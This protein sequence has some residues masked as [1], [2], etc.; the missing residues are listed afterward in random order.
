M[1]AAAHGHAKIVKILLGHG[2]SIYHANRYGQTA[3]DVAQ[4]SAGLIVR[5]YQNQYDKECVSIEELQNNI[6]SLKREYSPKIK[7][8]KY[9]REE[10]QAMHSQTRLKKI[11]KLQGTHKKLKQKVKNKKQTERECRSIL[12]L[13]Q[14]IKALD[15]NNQKYDRELRKNDQEYASGNYYQIYDSRQLNKKILRAMNSGQRKQMIQNLSHIQKK[16]KKKNQA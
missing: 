16:N 8:F 11:K 10:L 4:G 6:A 15:H 14:E 2:A 3:L 9:R 12:Q 5:E 1:Q 13:Q 7:I